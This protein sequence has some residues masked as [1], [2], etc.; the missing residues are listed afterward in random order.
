M[1]WTEIIQLRAYSQHDRDM[2]VSAFHQLSPPDHEKGLR[3][4]RLFRNVAL[5]N[6]LSIFI[7]WQGRVSQKGKTPLGL[8]LAA[9]F[10]QFGPIYHAVWMS[11]GSV[12]L[13]A[14]RTRYEEQR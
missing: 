9:A 3:D 7:S 11:E 2:A 5:Q 1:N 6:D 4:I 14:R 13:K 12:P 10:S 8:Q